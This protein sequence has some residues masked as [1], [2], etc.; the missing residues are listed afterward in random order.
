[1]AP[2]GS[3]WDREVGAERSVALGGVR[4]GRRPRRTRAGHARTRTAPLHTPATEAEARQ[5]ELPEAS[6]PDLPVTE[7]QLPSEAKRGLGGTLAGNGSGI[8]GDAGGNPR[9]TGVGGHPCP[10]CASGLGPRSRYRSGQA[11]GRAERSAASR[12]PPR[13]RAQAGA[14]SAS[15]ATPS[16][17][18][19]QRRL[20][21]M[22]GTAFGVMKYSQVSDSLRADGDQSIPFQGVIFSPFTACLM[23]T[24]ISVS[25]GWIEGAR[26]NSPQAPA[27]SRGPGRAP[28][29][30]TGWPPGTLGRLGGGRGEGWLVAPWGLDDLPPGQGAAVGFPH[31]GQLGAPRPLPG[32]SA[33][34]VLRGLGTGGAASC[35][36]PQRSVPTSPSRTSPPTSV[37][38]S[39]QRASWSQRESAQH[40]EA[41]EGAVD[42][43][44]KLIPASLVGHVRPCPPSPQ[45]PSASP[46]PRPPL[47]W[48]HTSCRGPW[49][50]RGCRRVLGL[51]SSQTAAGTTVRSHTARRDSL[52]AGPREQEPG[53]RSPG[54]APGFISFCFLRAIRSVS[55]S[56]ALSSCFAEARGAGVGGRPRCCWKPAQRLAAGGRTLLRRLPVR[57]IPRGGTEPDGG[58]RSFPAQ[59]LC[60][61]SGRVP[62]LAAGGRA[63]SPSDQ[64][65]WGQAGPGLPRTAKG[66][67]DLLQVGLWLET[68]APCSPECR[69]AQPCTGRW[70]TDRPQA[71]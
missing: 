38:T 48:D 21:C 14:S 47:S 54:H 4:G 12:W 11:W 42:E 57:R 22:D 7:K 32:R 68:A 24:V 35:S 40:R 60:R 28:G 19:P 52:G 69:G 26:Q 64:L 17:A 27:S 62:H 29:R 63:R 5:H 45:T 33:E 70:H 36:H 8:S 25:K 20:L 67:A 2:G 53:V 46:K 15:A 18:A 44:A 6:R 13:P 55:R 71:G 31:S 65:P 1:M 49:C 51:R 50:L 59:L 39:A 30:P 10:V 3:S 41:A 66:A 23:L 9:R 43:G 58:R 56:Q 61:C 16:L 34:Q 37:S